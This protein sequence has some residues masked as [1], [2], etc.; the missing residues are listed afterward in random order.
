MDCNS[1]YKYLKRGCREDEARLLSVVSSDR[2]RESGH[3]LKLV[4]T[5]NNLY[6]YRNITEV[7]CPP[8][9]KEISVSNKHHEQ[10]ESFVLFCCIEK[11]NNSLFRSAV[12]CMWFVSMCNFRL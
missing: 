2:T 9:S 6:E 5:K 11:C 3:K 10:S 7:D 4:S 12:N 8:S 1:V